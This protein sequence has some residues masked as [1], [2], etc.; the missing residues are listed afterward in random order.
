MT[1]HQNVKK[2][3]NMIVD[4]NKD[5]IDWKQ[6]ITNI[7][8]KQKLHDVIRYLLVDPDLPEKLQPTK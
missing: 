5:E 1:L 3:F 7:T 4:V 2:D 6:I 8:S